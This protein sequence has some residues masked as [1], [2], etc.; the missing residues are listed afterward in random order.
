M[1]PAIQ[2]SRER[3]RPELS[4]RSRRALLLMIVTGLLTACLEPDVTDPQVR[5]TIKDINEEF[6]AGYQQ[7]LREIGSRSFAVQPA[8]AMS[9]MER[10]LRDM[11]FQ[12]RRREGD[13]FLHVAAP[14]PL[15]LDSREWEVVREIDEPRMQAIAVNHLGFQ[16]NFARLEPDGIEIHG[17]VT[18]LPVPEGSGISLTMRMQEIKPPSPDSILPRR[19]YPPPH[20]VKMGFEKIWRRFTAHTQVPAATASRD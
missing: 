11:G 13:H 6:G 12:I 8:Q 15:P 10:V 1:T 3:R 9:G 5:D 18:V 20:A 4:R 7:V 2:T 16:G 19:E 17:F 14:A